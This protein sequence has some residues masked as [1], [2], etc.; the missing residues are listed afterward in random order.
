MQ[1]AALRAQRG[2]SRYPRR[3]LR[4][5]PADQGWRGTAEGAE[6]SP[7][8]LR[9]GD[10][11]ALS[12]A[13]ELGRGGADRDVSG[14]GLGA[15]CRGHHG[16]LVGHAG[17]ALDGVGPEQEDL[18]DD[19][20]VAQSADRGRASLRLSRRHRAQAQLGRRGA[21]RLAAGG[22]RRERRAVIGRFSASARGPRRTRRAGARSSSISRSAG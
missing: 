17:I 13:R 16:G 7:A 3:P 15:P 9:D 20:G 11:R 21:Q 19:R 1:C 12:A 10:H 6:A 4:A 22:D 14:G 18:R 5:Q 2:A 8:D